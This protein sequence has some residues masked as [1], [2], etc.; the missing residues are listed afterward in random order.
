VNVNETY[1]I[2]KFQRFNGR[3]T[4]I[5]TEYKHIDIERLA[6]KGYWIAMIRDDLG[7]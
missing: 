7:G 2:I 4:G 6:L 5:F 1:D 3:K